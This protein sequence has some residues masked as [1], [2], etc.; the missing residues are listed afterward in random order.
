MKWAINSSGEHVRAGERFAKQG[1]LRCPE[2]K[3]RVYHRQGP[4]RQAHFA[5][6]SGN[7]NQKC[8]L[9]NPGIGSSF[10]G[11]EGGEQEINITLI[12]NPT[13]G[14]PALIWREEQPIPLSL[15]L[16]MPQYINN[17][18]PTILVSSG[19]GQRRLDKKLLQ[20]VTFTP[21][22]LNIPPAVIQINPTSF[23]L[24]DKL[25]K[26]L[27]NFKHE[28]NIFR[29]HL[30]GGVLI[31]SD[32][33]IELGSTYFIVTQRQLP[34]ALPEALEI[35]RT[36]VDKSWTVYLVRLRDE[37][38]SRMADI[39]AIGSYL[40]RSVIPPRSKAELIWPSPMRYDLDGAPVYDFPT[41]Q[42]IVR[43]TSSSPVQSIC[44]SKVMDAQMLGGGLY[45][46]SIAESTIEMLVGIEGGRFQVVRFEEHRLARP[47]G[48]NV[49]PAGAATGLHMNDLKGVL[50]RGRPIFLTV[51]TNRLWRHVRINKKLL[52]PCPQTLTYEIYDAISEIDVGAFGRFIDGL[53]PDEAGST[54]QWFI[55]TEKIVSRMVG[56]VAYEQLKKVATKAQLLNWTVRNKA[57][58]IFPLMLTL[59]SAEVGRGVSRSK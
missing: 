6:F 15:M 54:Y 46:V 38:S 58:A 41:S 31:D 4:W 43:S 44:E 1:S 39:R 24:E 28:N 37:L 29:H 40:N 12:D 30:G 20:K 22:A 3:R 16:R 52:T 19:L 18:E 35:L 32:A 13:Q 2:C 26:I 23:Y 8:E 55:K 53:H 7:S 21:V 50:N 11:S 36:R 51:P 45:A 56:Q 5:H 34:S 57:Q 33:A 10:A 42:I 47:V 25:K 49:G 27:R 9:Y 14:I 17:D 48:V 59:L